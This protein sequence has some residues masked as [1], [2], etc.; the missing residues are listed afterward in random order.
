MIQL[1]PEDVDVIRIAA[2]ELKRKMDELYGKELESYREEHTQRVIS[3]LVEKAER[4]YLE[5]EGPV[6]EDEFEEMRGEL[7]RVVAQVVAEEFGV[8]V[9]LWP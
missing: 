1:P 8:T 9:K 5:E 4:R 3:N 2:R 6:P 7:K